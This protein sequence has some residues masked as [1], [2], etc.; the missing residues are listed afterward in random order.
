L[1]GSVAIIRLTSRWMR[2][3]LELR[4]QMVLANYLNGITNRP[5]RGGTD[6]ELEFECLKCL[7]VSLSNKVWSRLLYLPAY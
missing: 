3:W 6:V 4:G 2:N 5:N 7:K 1:S